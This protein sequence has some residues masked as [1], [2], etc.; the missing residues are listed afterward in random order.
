MNKATIGAIAYLLPLL[1]THDALAARGIHYG[2]VA[3]PELR[4]CDESDWRCERGRADSCYR[5][6]RAGTAPAAIRAEAA[7]AL[8]DLQAAN[9]LFRA[10]VHASPDVARLRVRW[11]DLFADSHQDGEAMNL[12]REAMELDDE[13][14]F[15]RLGAARVMAGGFDDAANS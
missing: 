7:W 5:A 12:Y 1:C 10:A 15:A 8:N 11:G 6:L 14:P 9:Q 2:A 4:E 13:D 3:D